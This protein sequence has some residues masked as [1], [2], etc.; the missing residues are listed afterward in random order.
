[1]AGD[2]LK[3]VQAGDRLNIPAEAYNAFIDAARA[4][5]SQ[6][7]LGADARQSP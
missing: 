5:R 6:Q 4:S 1:M 2:P 3:K 7:L